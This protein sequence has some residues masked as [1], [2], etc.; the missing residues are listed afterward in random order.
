MLN[1]DLES[2]NGLKPHSYIV[3][4]SASSNLDDKT[5]DK[6]KIIVDKTILKIKKTNILI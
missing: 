3:N 5:Y 2:L 6:K 1:S 4:F